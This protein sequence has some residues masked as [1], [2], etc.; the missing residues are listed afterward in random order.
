M[1]G[2]PEWNI[3]VILSYDRDT[4][5]TFNNHYVLYM[6]MVQPYCSLAIGQNLHF[7]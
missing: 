4:Q 5:C 7:I 2:G 1:V 6:Q 3:I